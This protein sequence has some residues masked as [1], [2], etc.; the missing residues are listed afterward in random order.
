VQEAEWD[1]AFQND[2]PDS[3]FAAIGAG[4][5]KDE[6]GKTVPRTLR[7]LPHHNAQGNLDLPHLRA[8]MARLN[9]IE[10]ASLQPEAKKHLCGHARSEKAED[11]VSEFC[12]EEPPK[13]SESDETVA[14]RKK[15][16]DL[17]AKLAESEKTLKQQTES[18]QAKYTDFR[19]MVESTIPPSH[20]WKAWTP[21]PQKLI[22]AQL[23]VLR[24]SSGS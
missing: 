21:G 20:I 24:E 10:P 3:A 22:Q 6:Q 14:L 18:L 2:L 1:Q 23:K 15:I 16:V 5:E 13:V 9:Q 19:K 8:A 12:G 11:L 7:H 4:G 17:E